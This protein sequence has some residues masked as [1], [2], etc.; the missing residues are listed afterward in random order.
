M[1]YCNLCKRNSVKWE[2]GYK[3]FICQLCGNEFD[4]YN[5]KYRR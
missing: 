2:I 4:Y 3:R 5:G 1:H